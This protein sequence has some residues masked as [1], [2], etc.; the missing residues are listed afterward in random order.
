M[1]NLKLR[2]HQQIELMQKDNFL[3]E[4]M[5][6]KQYSKT[7]PLK[8]PKLYW[9]IQ[10]DGDRDFKLR[11]PSAKKN[12]VKAEFL[13]AG[14]VYQNREDAE[15]IARRW[16]EGKRT[17]RVVAWFEPRLDIIWGGSKSEA[18]LVKKSIQLEI[19]TCQFNKKKDAIEYE[20]NAS[21]LH[22]SWLYEQTIPEDMSDKDRKTHAYY[23]PLWDKTFDEKKD[24]DL[25]GADIAREEED[26]LQS[27]AAAQIF[28][29]H[30]FFDLLSM[31]PKKWLLNQIFG[32]GDLGM[33]YGAAGCGK[34]FIVIDMII[35]LCTGTQWADRF[36]VERSLNVA[37]CAGEGISGLPSRFG[38]AAKHHGVTSLCNFTFYKTIPQLYSETQSNFHGTDQEIATIKQFCFEWKARQLSKESEAL[39]VL[40]VDTLHTATVT[41]DENSAKDM[42]KVLQACRSVADELGCA[43]ILVHHNNKTGSAERGS[44]S[45]RGAMDFMLAIK[46]SSD[47]ETKAIMSCS[48][49]KDGEQ[50]QDQPFDLCAVEDCNSVC[51][52]WGN[53]IDQKQPSRS[54][55][56]DKRTLREEMERHPNKRFICKVLAESIA[57]SD[58]YTRKL[59]NEMERAKECK[60]ELADPSKPV[61]SKNSWVYWIET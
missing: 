28:K 2:S 19:T 57:Q 50:W 36:D 51:V 37:Y 10:V 38:A 45:L 14:W 16:T 49:L 7:V 12:G 26:L 58:V 30:S 61:S 13:P 53:P 22:H 8:Q 27:K 35:K 20:C 40:I 34:T 39:D 52:A 32:A 29:P 55:T 1:T 41:A 15:E 47:I 9:L 6:Q 43:V 46:R 23:K 33:I 18:G 25:R 11:A 56:M 4:K 17:L 24:I 3:N 54:K 42:G 48:K 44:S 60:R 21:G 31:P 5:S 59:L